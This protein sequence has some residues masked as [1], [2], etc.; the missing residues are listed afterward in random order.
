MALSTVGSGLDI[1]S[2]VSQL[3]AA[4]RAPT[5]NRINTAGTAATAKLSALGTI[6]S[7]LSS[8][9]GAM[10]SLSKS[11]TTASFKA[12]VPTDAG[13][14]ASTST[15]AVAGSYQVEV[16]SLSTAQK[17]TSGAFQKDA[18]IGQ[19]TLSLA[20]GTD[21]TLEVEIAAD[22]KLEDIA[23][24]INTAAGGKGVTASII[25]ANDGQHLVLNSVDAGTA[26]AIRVS[27]SG[28]G[29]DAFSWD[30]TSGNLT[31]AVKAADAKVVVDGFERTSSSNS[32]SDLIPGITLTLTKAGEGTKSTLTVS[33][34]NTS[35]KTNLQAFVAAY[36]STTT[37]LRS[38]SSYNATS[39]TAAA[40]TGDALVRGLQ[41]QMRTLVSGNVSDLKTLGVSI[42][43][44]GTLTLD[45]GTFE[46]AIAADPTGAAV[47]FG[48][49]GKLT[50]GLKTI[51][52]SQL[53]STSG[54][55]AQRTDNLNKQIKKLE[56]ELDDLDL[57]MEKV[58][59][60]Y[61]AQFTAMDQLVTQ[62]QSTSDYLTQQ[63][64][65]LSSS[66]SK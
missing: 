61:T 24:A 47:L 53:D 64:A 12:N 57:R 44:D 31:E 33:Q 28:T 21:N 51:I 1:P 60:R 50:S 62:M 55:L 34:D 48:A 30:G 58:A 13:F 66:K 20:W 6:K 45:S 52:T 9:Q 23:K 42:A 27:A 38:S 14:T 63:L 54:V 32:I 37:V 49:E 41:Q 35:L 4:E 11:A 39:N 59:A 29:L 5:Q 8:L 19:G 43:L 65:S 15:G 7:S 17:L 16:V 10:E 26:G 3:V 36:N 56:R 40:L 18:A 2:L 46:K 22:S 25:T